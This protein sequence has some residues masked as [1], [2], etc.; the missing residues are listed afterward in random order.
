MRLFE[1]PISFCDQDTI[2]CSKMLC[3]RLH[4]RPGSNPRYKIANLATSLHEGSRTP[5][6]LQVPS[7]LRTSL[8]PCVTNVRKGRT[9]MK[10]LM[11][12]ATFTLV[13]VTSGV[14]IAL[15]ERITS[16]PPLG[17]T[18]PFKTVAAVRSTL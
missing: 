8:H 3:A 7:S 14:V 9:N 13:M 4:E 1:Q 2:H 5:A 12:L 18:A 17:V 10:W 16:T 6:Q 15:D 11:T